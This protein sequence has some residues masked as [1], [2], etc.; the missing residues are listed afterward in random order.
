MEKVFFENRALIFLDT[1]EHPVLQKEDREYDYTDMVKLI[2]YVKSTFFQLKD[3]EK[4]YIRS[5]FKAQDLLRDFCEG[6]DI[7]KAAGGI[8]H[9]SQNNAR[10]YL[11]IYRL[12]YWDL[13]KGKREKTDTD[14]ETTARREIEEETGIGR[15]HCIRP[16]PST[17]HFY[18]HKGE[19]KLKKSFWFEF[20]TDCTSDPKPQQEEDIETAVFLSKEEILKTMPRMYSSIAYLWEYYFS[21]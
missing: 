11:C 4:I 8:V 19:Y 5:P 1:D 14:I 7:I 17:Y 16:L 13:P 12:N 3:H 20:S 10:E 21:I 18:L 9:R 15:L 2:K 6:F